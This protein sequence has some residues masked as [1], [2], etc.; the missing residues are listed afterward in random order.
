M[1]NYADFS[2]ATIATQT[3]KKHRYDLNAAINAYFDGGA[4]GSSTKN[5]NVKKVG[6]IWEQYK[7]ALGLLFGVA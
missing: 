5:E 4:V 1:L 7:G 2:S 3:L 6:D